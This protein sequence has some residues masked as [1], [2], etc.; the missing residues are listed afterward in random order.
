MAEWSKAGVLKTSDVN[1]I[2]RFKSYCFR[3]LKTGVPRGI[4]GSNPSPS[5][6]FSRIFSRHLTR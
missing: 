4:G 2:R 1:S 6:S 5:A 3:Q